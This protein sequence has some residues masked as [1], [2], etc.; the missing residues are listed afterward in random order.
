MKKTFFSVL[1]ISLLIGLMVLGTACNVDKFTQF[2]LGPYKTSITIPGTSTPGQILDSLFSGSVPTNS[3]ATFS[4]NSTGKDH[5]EKITLKEM[6]LRV[7]DPANGNFNFLKSVTVYI[8]A[9]G[10]PQKEIATKTTIANGL[11]VIDMDESGED[12][13][14]YLSAASFKLKT[15]VEF[16][17]T[18]AQD[19]KVEIATTYFVDAKILTK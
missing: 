12:I 16:D 7:T 18:P 6:T 3:E 14:D 5:I 2:N 10:L 11:N 9:D 8:S 13:K 17:G 4:G 15:K 1:S 19:T